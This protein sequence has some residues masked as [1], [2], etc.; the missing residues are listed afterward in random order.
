MKYLLKNNTKNIFNAS[1]TIILIL[2]AILVS[3]TSFAQNRPLFEL[4][5]PNSL[6]FDKTGLL[7]PEEQ[8]YLN[9]KLINFDN[10]TSVQI[11]IAVTPKLFGYDIADYATR[12]L[13][14]WK[15]GD[16][17]KDNGFI[18]LIKP[19]TKNSKGEI[20]IATG[21]GV[22]QYVT[23][24]ISKTIVEKEI[25][26]EF[27]KGNYLKGI[28]NGINV[29]MSLTK[30]EFT[31]S[32]YLKKQKKSSPIIAIIIMII[33]F[34]VFFGGRGNKHHNIGRNSSLPFWLLLMSSHSGRSSGGFGGFSSGSGGFGGFGGGMGGGGGAGGSW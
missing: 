28:D 14:T 25:I 30:G 20:F 12:L 4:P 15:P 32:Q 6:V 7:T 19:K 5:P 26:P 21:Y 11:V 34:L 27:K 9:Q 29:I 10:E 13:E 22:E 16:K 18:I 1:K 17:N 24:A 23:D 8:N 2:L 33:I 31:G 3:Q